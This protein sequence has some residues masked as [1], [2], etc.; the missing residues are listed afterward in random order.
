MVTNTHL[1]KGL[2]SM[3]MKLK[4]WVET[5]K[6]LGV[7][8][9]NKLTWHD[10]I[11]YIISKV[12]KRFYFLTL[13]KRSNIAP[14]DIVLVYISTIRSALEYACEIWHPSLGE[15]L[16][17]QLEGQQARAL[18]IAYPN[19]TYEQ[20]LQTS[21]LKTLLERREEFCR[22]FF[23]NIC[24]TNHPLNHLIPTERHHVKSL[25]YP[26]KYV[27]PKVRTNRLKCSPIYYG[28]FNYQ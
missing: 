1:P 5:T 17:A 8:L 28:F 3:P 22:Q 4:G 14:N 23:E 11:D 20:A 15:K 9:N 25:R 16:S 12:S 26:K 21:G 13:L 24:K 6:P 27:I 10:H 2:P 19:V 7:I 18:K